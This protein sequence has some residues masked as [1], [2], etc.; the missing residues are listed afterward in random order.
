[1]PFSVV[2]GTGRDDIVRDHASGEH[3]IELENLFS[4]SGINRDRDSGV[5]VDLGFRDGVQ[6]FGFPCIEFVK[7]FG[8]GTIALTTF[9]KP[10]SPSSVNELVDRLGD[11]VVCRDP[12]WMSTSEDTILDIGEGMRWGS[13]EPFE[14]E[15]CIVSGLF[16]SEIHMPARTKALT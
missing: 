12:V 7:E 10:S 8:F 6:E 13:L 16:V 1:M 14:E 3:W 11:K 9:N 2:L 5:R 4:M 15:I